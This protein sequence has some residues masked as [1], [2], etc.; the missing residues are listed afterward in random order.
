MDQ[1][2][3]KN[4]KRYWNIY[5]HP[6]QSFQERKLLDKDFKKLVFVKIIFLFFLKYFDNGIHVFNEIMGKKS[7]T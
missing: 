3:F 6:K 2:G 7:L 5:N 4:P 1:R